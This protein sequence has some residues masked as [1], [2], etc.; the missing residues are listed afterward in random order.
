M[1]K[2]L[3]LIT[4]AFP[5]GRGEQFLESEVDILAT[6]FD[7]I[8]VVPQKKTGEARSLPEN[9]FVDKGFA[10]LVSK[11]GALKRVAL[12]IFIGQ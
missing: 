9:F 6:Q 1:S 8:V 7:R 12:A 4:T 11:D 10:T 2:T 5:F 3:V